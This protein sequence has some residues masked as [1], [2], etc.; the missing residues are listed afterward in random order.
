ML[1]VQERDFELDIGL[2][3]QMIMTEEFADELTK[4][5]IKPSGKQRAI[6]YKVGIDLYEMG[7]CFKQARLLFWS[8]PSSL[9]NNLPLRWLL[10]I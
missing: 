4:A 2:Q 10:T 7:Y 1:W 6:Y 9:S 3:Q 8:A 5:S